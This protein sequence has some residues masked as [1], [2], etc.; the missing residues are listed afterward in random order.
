MHFAFINLV[1][2]WKISVY[3]IVNLLACLS[4]FLFFFSIKRKKII[5]LKLPVF[6]QSVS[7]FSCSVMCE[8]FTILW[9]AARQVSLSITSSWSL[10]TLMTFESV[11][12]SN[13]LI[14]CHPLLLC[15]QTFPAL[16][17]FQMSQLFASGGQSIGVSA[18]ASVLLL[19]IQDWFLLGW[20]GWI[21][22]SPRDSQE[23]S[24]TSQFKSINSSVLSFLYTPTLTSIH[25]WKSQSLDW[26][27]LRSQSNFSA[28]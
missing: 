20:T 9:T 3:S 11:M 14:L 17:F 5:S 23:S 19:N 16:G 24:P 8:I 1:I 2:S 26:T 13:H 10:L 15:L 25:D 21:S 6:I 7:Q 18:S 27:D 4:K 22:C 28:F 12:P